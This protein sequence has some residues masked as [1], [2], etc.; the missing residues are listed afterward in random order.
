MAQAFGEISWGAAG[1]GSG[2]DFLK[3]KDGSNKVRIVSDPTK[4]TVHWVKDSTNATRKVNCAVDNCPVCHRGQDGDRA[5]V[6][7]IV[8]AL[9][10]SDGKVKLLEIGSQAFKQI[11]DLYNDPEYGAVQQYDINIKRGAKGSNPLY[12]VIPLQKSP[13]TAEE[14]KVVDDFNAKTDLSAIATPGT[15]EGILKK[16]GWNAPGAQQASGVSN[17]FVSSKKATS[18]FSF[19]D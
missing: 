8:K 9:D 16:L 15:P 12:T 4:M 7:W 17:E 13:M 11:K 3:L 5:S 2:G 6:K 14:Q 10:R 1:G 18:D 19:D